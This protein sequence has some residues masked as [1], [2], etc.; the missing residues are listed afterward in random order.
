MTGFGDRLAVFRQRFLAR[1]A[2]DA[3]AMKAELDVEAWDDLRRRTHSLAGNAGLFGFPE[4][5]DE[6][7]RLEEA[8]DEDEGDEEIVALA[9]RLIA[10]LEALPPPA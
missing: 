5:T 3:A 2:E 7:R 9:R 8:I 10:T 6:A 4:I 1:A